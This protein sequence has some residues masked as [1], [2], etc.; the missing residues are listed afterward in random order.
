MMPR[1]W[2][3]ECARS[4]A[5]QRGNTTKPPDEECQLSYHRAPG[6]YLLC[7]RDGGVLTSR[8]DLRVPG[9]SL[10]IGRERQGEEEYW[11]I[12]LVMNSFEFTDNINIAE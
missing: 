8:G 10:R 3:P 4:R 11:L 9:L 5:A 1:K 6:L 7:G 12:N 2:Q